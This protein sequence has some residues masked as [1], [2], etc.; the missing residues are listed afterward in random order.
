MLAGMAQS[1]I[2]GDTSLVQLFKQAHL[3]LDSKPSAAQ[4][5]W[6]KKVDEEMQASIAIGTEGH[7]CSLA[8]RKLSIHG[9]ELQALLK[10]W[11]AASIGMARQEQ[12]M[13]QLEPGIVHI[14][15]VPG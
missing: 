10:L 1:L 7:T 12:R 9:D 13:Q 8:G 4:I 5:I 15:Y 2:T 3:A 11:C 14:L 6:A